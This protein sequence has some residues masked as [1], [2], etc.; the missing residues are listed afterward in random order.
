MKK[1]ERKIVYIPSK[2]TLSQ[3]QIVKLLNS[4]IYSVISEK[5]A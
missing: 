2:N 1:I 3:E 4:Y 5:A